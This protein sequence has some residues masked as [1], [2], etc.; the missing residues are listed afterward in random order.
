MF[1][2]AF[3]QTAMEGGSTLRELVEV[4][5]M[6]LFLKPLFMQT[7]PLDLE[8][9]YPLTVPIGTS[10]SRGVILPRTSPNYQ[11]YIVDSLILVVLILLLVGVT[12]A[13]SR[14]V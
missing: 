1:P 3:P 6:S 8:E 12:I 10:P 13:Y 14:I 2:T 11:V 4:M 7:V 5:S 9:Q